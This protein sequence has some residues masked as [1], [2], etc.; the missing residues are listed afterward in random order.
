MASDRRDKEM[1]TVKERHN[2]Q[3]RPGMTPRT[4]IQL[5]KEPG[6]L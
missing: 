6:Q 5:G 4:C 2:R 1:K 3:Y